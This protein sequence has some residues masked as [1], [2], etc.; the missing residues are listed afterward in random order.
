MR[1][2][3]WIFDRLELAW[4]TKDVGALTELF[5]EDCV[6]EDLAL[7]VRHEGHEGVREFAR[8]VFETMPDFSLTFPVRVV[9]PER[10]SSHWVIRAHWNG[11]FEGVDRTGHAIE[12][13]GLSSY[14]F[15][16]GKIAHNIDCWNYVQMIDGFGVVPARLAALPHVPGS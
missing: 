7:G 3:E 11:L 4:S 1:A 2:R 13:N 9:T 6:Y 12:F 16:D 15:S 5:T 10:G 8:G 14:R